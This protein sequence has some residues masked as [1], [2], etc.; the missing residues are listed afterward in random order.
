MNLTGLP[1]AQRRGRGSDGARSLSASRPDGDVESPS[2]SKKAMLRRLELRAGEGHRVDAP[3][4][5]A[6]F[7]RDAAL[8]GS[9]ENLGRGY[10]AVRATRRWR[11]RDENSERQG[12]SGA[13]GRRRARPSSS[14]TRSTGRSRRVAFRPHYRWSDRPRR[15]PVPRDTT[16]ADWLVAVHRLRARR[17]LPA[18]A[19]NLRRLLRLSPFHVWEQAKPISR[20]DLMGPRGPQRPAGGINGRERFSGSA[21][22]FPGPRTRVAV[23]TSA[24]GTARSRG[25]RRRPRT[26]RSCSC[27]TSTN[28]PSRSSTRGARW[29]KDDVLV[30]SVGPGG[31]GSPITTFGSYPGL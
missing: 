26:S 13:G 9:P 19:S 25:P 28:V 6:S 20:R 31:I 10:G 22:F 30:R 14:C 27:A 7:T 3:R 23:Q 5:D 4:D 18:T 11:V 17:P 1:R 29:Y 12:L 21:N 16:T 2:S 15:T 24:C 8:H